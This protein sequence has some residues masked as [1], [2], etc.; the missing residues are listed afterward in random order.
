M[1][2]LLE[3]PML[4][5]VV[6]ALVVILGRSHVYRIVMMFGAAQEKWIYLGRAVLPQKNLPVLLQD[7]IYPIQ[8]CI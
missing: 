6:T 1:V 4:T 3:M 2:T 8:L 5:S 7:V